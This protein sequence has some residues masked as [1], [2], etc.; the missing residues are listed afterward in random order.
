MAPLSK[1]L[2]GVS[3]LAL[4]L[5]SI[6]TSSSSTE[7]SVTQWPL[8]NDGYNKVVEWDHYSFQIDDQRIFVFSGEFHYWR[9]PV[10]GLWRDILEK[11]KAAGFTAFSFYSNWAYHAPNNQT[12]DFSTGAHDIAP[13]YELAEEIGLYILVRPGPYINAETTAGGFPLWLTTG[14]YGSL[15]NNDTRYTKA[16]TPYFTEMSKITSKYQVTNG[17]NTIGYQIENEYGDQWVSV[18]EKTP[19]NTA[20]AYMELLEANARENGITVPLTANDPNMNSWS[21]GTDYTNGEGNVDIAGVDSYPSCW[22]CDISQCDSTNGAYVA[23]QVV[24]YIDYFSE[25]SPTLPGFMPEFQ[26]GSYNPWGGPEG[27]CPEDTGADFANLFYRWNIGQRVTAMS[28]YMIFGGTNWGGIATPVTATSYDYS[29]PISEDRSIGSKYYETKLLALFTRTA[30]DLPKTDLIG[31]GTQYT[32]NSD[33]RAYELRNPDT[34]AGFYATFHSNTSTDTNEAFHLKVDTSVG[35]LTVPQ[36]GGVIRLNG[37]QSKIIVTD[38]T[39]GSGSLLYSTAEVLTYAVFDKVPTLVLWVPTGESGEFNVKGAKKGSTKSCQGCSDV[40]FIKEKGGLT[41]TFTQSYGMSV[42]EID[43]IR[44]VILDRTYAYTF[45]APALTTNPFVPE[46]ESVLVSGPYLVRGA[47]QSGSKL[48]LTGDIVNT[49]TLVEVFAEEKVKSL[50]W[51]GNS[52]KTTRT[53][54]GS[55]KGYVSAP[56]AIDL[57]ALTSWKYKDSLPERF[58]SYDDSGIAWVAADHMTTLNPRTPTYLPVLYADEY[59]F[60]NGIRLWRGY[61]ND[62]ATAVSLNVQGG[63]AFGWSAWLNGELLGSFFGDDTSEQYNLTLS[64]S[65]VTVNTDTPNVL[66]VVHDDTGHDETTGALNPRG[67]LD[68]SL[69]GSSSGFTHWRLAGTAGGE[70]NLDPVRGVYNED[71]LHA[72]RVGWHLP[73]FDASSWDSVKG[74]DLTFEGATV[75]FF[76]TTVS[77]DLPTDHDVSVSFVLGTPTGSPLTYRTQLFVN[78]YQYGRFNPYI[79]NQVEFPVPLGVL[80]YQGENTISVA[81]WAQSEEGAGISVDWKVNYVSTT[82]LDIKEIDDASLRPVWTK[83]RLEYA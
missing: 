66:L 35:K 44:V 69:A 83:E 15:R 82:S 64:F 16:W 32:D 49:T 77:L 75:R 39:F 68:V 67:I 21:W 17:H 26:G 5:P 54:Y 6:A 41:A 37:H 46:T 8:H 78:G 23:Y 30:K 70:S 28:L 43:D 9:I 57:P 72:E 53:A 74:S 11:I 55:L 1:I 52:V 65:N 40:K 48:A 20:I 24:D 4:S 2:S 13:L 31:N 80:N 79:G 51:N 60:H 73:G 12:L 61:F 62:S 27:G 38:F 18:S 14:D 58:A 10:P 71:G 25:Y 59:G 34:N 63:T 22:T 45:W 42:L 50:T 33:V 81:V 29:A 7:D 3:L 56:K 76:R 36:H 47:S 19:N